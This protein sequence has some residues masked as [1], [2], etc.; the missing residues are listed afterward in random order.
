MAIIDSTD[1]HSQSQLVGTML[2]PSFNHSICGGQSSLCGAPC[3]GTF[4]RIC[5]QLSNG[6]VVKRI[7]VS[8]GGGSIV[9]ITHTLVKQHKPIFYVFKLWLQ[10][11]TDMTDHM[12]HE[13]R[14]V[15]RR[16]SNTVSKTAFSDTYTL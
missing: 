4:P 12:D 14:L 6:R 5:L 16:Q 10:F 7:L 1:S 13:T 2:A 3:P 11:M 15:N 8:S 9:V